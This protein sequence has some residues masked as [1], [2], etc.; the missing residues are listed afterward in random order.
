MVMVYGIPSCGTVKK[1]RSW[2][3]ERGIEHTFVDFRATPAGRERITTW[4]EALGA[5]ALRNTSGKAY[6][7]LPAERSAWDDAT[8][9]DRFEEDA[10]LLKRPVVEVGGKPVM[11]GFRKPEV[12]EAALQG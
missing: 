10:M 7:A 8:W 6:R 9:I 4:V 1:A 3:N 5:K 2:L 12:L 11:A